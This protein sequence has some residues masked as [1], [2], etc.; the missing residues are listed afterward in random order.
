VHELEGERNDTPMLTPP[1]RTAPLRN[2]V[3]VEEQARMATAADATTVTSIILLRF[4]TTDQLEHL[5]A[6]ALTPE[7][8]FVGIHNYGPPGLATYQLRYDHADTAEA[9]ERILRILDG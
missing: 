5:P 4:R 2:A 6:R 9:R 3:R 1:A 7:A 8:G